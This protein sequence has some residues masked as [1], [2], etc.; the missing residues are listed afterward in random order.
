MTI[1]SGDCKMTHTNDQ[2]GTF[3]A[4]RVIILLMCAKCFGLAWV[5]KCVAW[6]NKCVAWVNKCV[7]WVNK[8]VAWVNKC[9]GLMRQIFA[10]KQQL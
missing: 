10:L 9:V 1:H 5:N 2:V 4:G 6:V 8:Y 7:A 3:H